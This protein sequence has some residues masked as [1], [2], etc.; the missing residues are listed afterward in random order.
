[1]T[2]KIN[3]GGH[4]FPVM[5][6]DGYIQEGMSKREWFAGMAL[7]GLLTAGVIANRSLIDLDEAANAAFRV[8]DLMIKESAS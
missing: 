7:H 5:G 1:M 3:D 4:A 8:A 6:L 2:D